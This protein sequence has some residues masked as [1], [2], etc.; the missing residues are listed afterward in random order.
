M[1][2]LAIGARIVS[3]PCVKRFFLGVFAADEVKLALVNAEVK[4]FCVVN[5]SGSTQEGAHWYVLFK[6]GDF[7]Y[8]TFDSLGQSEETARQRV[9]NAA[10]HCVYNT[11]PVQGNESKLCGEF[12]AYFCITRV[13]NY[14]ETFEEI[15]REC[16][17]LDLKFN[18]TIVERFWH[19]DEL[20]DTD[21]L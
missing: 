3:I 19:C 11:T 7:S 10:H 17:T 13:L 9:G 2:G 15:F 1:I 14:E 21:L 12:A 5:T 4:S 16:F 20:Y 8:E 6:S 18:D